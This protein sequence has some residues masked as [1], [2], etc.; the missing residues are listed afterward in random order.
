[1]TILLLFHPRKLAGF[2]VRC[3]SKLMAEAANNDDAARTFV[4][5]DSSLLRGVK[6]G[7]EEAARLLFDRYVGRLQ[8]LAHRQLAGQIS[9]RLDAEDVTQSI[10]RTLF[11]RLQDGQYSVPKGD[12]IWRLLVTIALN[13]IRTVGTHHR[14]AKRD[15]R[16]STDLETGA[17]GDFAPVND[18]SAIRLLRM[19]I[20]EVLDG[21]SASQQRIIEL[22]LEGNTVSEI[23]AATKRSKRT[24]ERTLQGF[25]EKLN[26]VLCEGDPH[27]ESSDP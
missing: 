20:E 6:S 9:G 22:R 5:S 21:L 7:N 8:A 10:F 24:V 17:L 1:M 11:R 19:T 12:S 2:Q 23:A 27:D 14:A 3:D 4:K 13:K 26:R 25:R 18:E 16:R 15:I